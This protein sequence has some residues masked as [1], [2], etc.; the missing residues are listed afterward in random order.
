[1]ASKKTVYNT[2]KNDKINLLF[3]VPLMA[4]LAIV[5]LIVFVYYYDCGL[6]YYDFFV[7]EE[8]YF[9]NNGSADFFLY[10]KMLVFTV[11]AVIMAVL[12]VA[13]LIME[14]GR[15]KFSKVFIPLGVYAILA[16]VSSLASQYK[17]FPFDGIYEQF[18]S[19]WA[20]LGYALVAYYAFL[21]INEQRDFELIIMALLFSTVI[22][23]LIG[24]SQAFFTD[25]YQT[26][27][28]T[29][30]IVP[31]KMYKEMV[32]TDQHLTF[33][34]EKGRVYMSLYNPNYV[35]SYVS[36]LTPFFMM[37]IFA[38]K[39]RYMKI[40]YGV[41]AIGLILALLGSQSR[42]GIVGVA[43]A[44]LLLV[45][46]FNRQLFRHWFPVTAAAIILIGTIYTYNNYTNGLI[47]NKIKS[48]FS[49]AETQYE[50]TNI[51]TLDEAV[52]M[53]Y[54]GNDLYF[55]CYYDAETGYF[56]PVMF[57]KDGNKIDTVMEPS[58]VCRPDDDRFRD[59]TVSPIQLSEELVGFTVNINGKDWY[60]AKVQD[61]FYMLTPY[62]KF[63]KLRHSEGIDWLEKHGRFASG[64]GFIWSRTLPLL[65]DKI[66][67]GSGADTFI[68][69]FPNWDFLA[70]YN[71]GYDGQ[72]M[73]KPHN[74]YLQMAVQTGVISVIAFLIY[75][76]WFFFSSM[77]ICFK[78]RKYTFASFVGIGCLAG[79]FGYMVV[80]L[81]NDSSI[82]VAPIYWTLTGVG[83]AAFAMVKKEIEADA[84]EGLPVKAE[85]SK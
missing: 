17:P 75:Y 60:Y 78:I 65:K 24:L 9:A 13:K 47:T 34:F 19:V 62:G 38:T 71:G 32:A 3:L 20:L 5:P 42:A 48:A 72:L 74:M 85:A 59:V 2:K 29:W 81:I 31:S 25:F 36:L 66:L 21:F 50:L 54:K 7:T 23:L 83:L 46:I 14:K 22:M 40:V 67:L 39:R 45:V 84:G 44:I 8:S 73:T 35:G 79:S 76:A 4:V 64:R 49:T 55:A 10:Y 41:L 18:E 12:L 70:L 16:L 26:E 52:L 61:S 33:N 82:S 6:E 53:T 51:E 57:D 30:A 11:I 56:Y 80:Q 77:A 37:L 1:M 43:F 63:I 58:Y 27:L 28:G 69:E 68:F 15:I